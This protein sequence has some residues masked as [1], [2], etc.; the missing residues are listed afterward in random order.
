MIY[1]VTP[2]LSVAVML[3]P[4]TV[5]AVAV[6]GTVKVETVG[7]VVSPA[8]AGWLA[9]FPGNVKA[10][11]SVMFVNPSLSESADSIDLKL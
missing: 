4:D 8:A 6:A 1:P 3:M 9:A 10:V 11:I 2:T 7:G 5:R